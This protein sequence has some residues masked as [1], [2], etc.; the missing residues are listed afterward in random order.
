MNTPT[1]SE[2]IITGKMKSGFTSVEKKYF[3]SI[4]IPTGNNYYCQ[5]TA[6]VPN[7]P[8]YSKLPNVVLTLNNARDRIQI[9]FPSALD[10]S[11]F[12]DVLNRFVDSELKQ[13]NAAHTEATADYQIFR[14]LLEANA[15]LRAKKKAEAAYNKQKDQENEN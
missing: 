12:A 14:E 1:K 3:K 4:K 9:L 6:W 7:T 8:A 15:D 11:E 13:I 10:L 2:I 5:I